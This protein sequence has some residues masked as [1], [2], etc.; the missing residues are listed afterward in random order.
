MPLYRINGR[1]LLF[2]HIPK[3]GG[4]S[5]E[6]SL[7][8][9]GSEALNDMAYLHNKKNFSKCSAQHFH[10]PILNRLAPE[11]F[12]DANFAILRDP[13]ARLKSEFRYRQ[14]L[15]TKYPHK[16]GKWIKGEPS[17]IN[18]W[19]KLSLRGYE[20]NPFIY[21]NHLRPQ[22]EFLRA[23]TQTFRL[24]NGLG[25]V[26]DWISQV[27]GTAVKPPSKTKLKSPDISAELSQD[28]EADVRSFYAADYEFL[29]K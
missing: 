25:A 2:T 29:S 19:V 24:E 26:F 27:M 5:V 21:D 17:E 23:D 6:A 8:A 16:W 4:S 9:Q 28:T 1:T 12:V 7:R 14:W 3:T 18:E 10:A 13:I 15:K 22:S 11:G 20:K